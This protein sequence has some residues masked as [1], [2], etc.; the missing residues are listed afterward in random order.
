MAVI[1]TGITVDDGTGFFAE[2]LDFGWNGISREAIDTTSMASTN[3]RTFTPATLY[4]GGEV[5]VEV[6]FDPEVSPLT[7]MS[8]AA[9]T[10][11]VTYADAAPASTMTAS[12]FM[13]SF[14]VNGPLENK[15]TATATLKVAGA[16]T[17]G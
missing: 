4:D 1:T 14:T 17:H 12:A 16:I 2:I 7:P 13:T 15:M 6:I 5:E 8:A 9:S 11:T 10:W 3:A